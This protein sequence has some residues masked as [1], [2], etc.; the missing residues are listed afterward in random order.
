MENYYFW[1]VKMTLAGGDLV[2]PG[3]LDIILL[4]D[5]YVES[6]CNKWIIISDIG[7]SKNTAEQPVGSRY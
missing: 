4:G 3:I 1:K 6:I 2:K 7:T 5:D